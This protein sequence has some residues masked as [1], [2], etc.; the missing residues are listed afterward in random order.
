MQVFEINEVAKIVGVDR[1]KAKNWTASHSAI[2]SPS[3][4]SARG[5]GS[6][7]LYSVSDVYRMG[8]AYELRK[9]GMAV[10]PIGKVLNQI[11]ARWDRFESLTLWRTSEFAKFEIREGRIS[12]PADVLLWQIVNVADLIRR[13]DEEIHKIET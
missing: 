1:V 9:G 6:R 4:R 3:I 11:P 2:L 12:P 7:N 13:I 10:Q 5:T 8:L